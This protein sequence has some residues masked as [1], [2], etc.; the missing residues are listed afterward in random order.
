MRSELESVERHNRE[1]HANFER[2]KSKPLLQSEYLRFYREIAKWVKKET[3]GKIVELGSGIGQ[4]RRVIPHCVL[5]D[6]FKNPWIDQ[7]ESAYQL[8][9]QQESVSHL[10]LFDVFHHLQYPGDALN[11]FYRVL[12]KGG[13][14]ILFEPAA[15]FLG[16]GVYGLFHPEPLGLGQE[17]TWRAKNSE[18]L[19]HTSYYAAQGNAWRIFYQNEFPRDQLAFWKIAHLKTWSA[20]AYLLCGGFSR[21]SFYSEEQQELLHGLENILDTFPQVTA[22]RMLVVLEKNG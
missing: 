20:L 21:P 1:I 22:S 13:R 11:E 10:I 6:L 8:S 4:I 15:G 9:F 16:R 7:Q 17:I 14:V 2:W 3:T 19:A 5:T 18:T 12:V